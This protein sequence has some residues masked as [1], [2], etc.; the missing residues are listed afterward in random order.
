MN[1]RADVIVVGGGPAGAGTA[2]QLARRGARVLLLERS[3][4]PR[5]KPCAECLSPQ[6]SRILRDM[7]VLDSLGARGAWLKGMT[8]RAPN[9][10]TMRGDYAASHGFHAYRDAGLAI[11]R[12]RLDASLIDAARGAGVEVRESSR[13]T[14]VIEQDGRVS[15]VRVLT[16]DASHDLHAGTVVAADG[17]RSIIARRLGLARVSRWPDRIAIVAHYHGVGGVGAYGEMHV[18]RDGFV[19]IADVGEG[20]TTVAAVFPRSRAREIQ[21]DS[22]S[23]LERWLR[24]KPHLAP[25]FAGATRDGDARAIGPFASHARRASHPGALLVGDAADFF[26][27]FTGEGIYAAL[28]GAEL[29]AD[30]IVASASRSE[31][32]RGYDD[33]RRAEFGGKWKVERMIGSAVAWP[34]VLNRAVGAL[35]ARK[36]LA[37]LIVGVTG[38][39]VPADR[40]LRLGFLAQLFLMPQFLLHR[41]A[42]AW[43]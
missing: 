4:F 1:T 12:E 42:P 36:E 41:P 17:L 27:P 33:A 28:R 16:G 23:F 5:P 43:R 25:R 18:E 9:G 30:W 32:L 24:A 38:D 7:G 21:G 34:A 15:G 37:D 14:D 22:F 35:A 11:R 31:A 3:R 29:A 2:F 40:V 26:D 8:V 13:V 10:V 20:V 6:A 39:F 19:G